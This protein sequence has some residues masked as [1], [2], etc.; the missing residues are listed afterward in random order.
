M[1]GEIISHKRHL[2][3]KDDVK[4]VIFIVF[5]QWN[6]NPFDGGDFIFIDWWDLTQQS[7]KISPL[8]DLR[9]LFLLH[10]LI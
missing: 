3:E 5:L 6:S 1:I 4:F 9:L 10:S 8:Y 2:R 7:F